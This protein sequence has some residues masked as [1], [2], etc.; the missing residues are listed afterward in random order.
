MYLSRLI[1]MVL[2]L[3]GVTGMLVAQENYW[4]SFTDKKNSTFSINRPE[5]FLS[6]R[7]IQ[8]RIR[9][10]IATDSLDLPVNR[11]YISQVLIPGVTLV[12]SSKWLNGIT[13]KSEIDTFTRYARSLPFVREVIR[14]KR[15]IA[16]K[17]GI[18]KFYVPTVPD[19][20]LPVD[21]SFYGESVFQVTQLNGHYL[22]QRGFL[23]QGIHIAVLDGGF[24]HADTLSA[25]DSLW[26]NGQILG[27]KDF[28]DPGEP[29]FETNYHGMSVLSC[30]GGNLP[31]KLMGTAPKASYWLIRSEDTG[32]EFII[33]ED[34][35]VAAA[36]FAD[37]AGVDIINSSLGYSLFDDPLTQ[38]T[39]ADMDG[40]TTRVT[41]GA[42][43]AASRGILV[44]S[45][46]GNEGNKSWKYIIAP[47]DGDLVIGV[48]AVSRDG[49]PAFFT[50]Y[51]P[52]SDGDIKP[53]VS[54]MG[55]NTFL[56]RNTGVT[57]PGSG[58]SFSSPVVTGV[59]ACLWQACPE[60]TAAE[61]KNAIEKSAHLYESPD[62][63]LGYG[64][65]DMIRAARF[66][67]FTNIPLQDD[68]NPWH[69]YPNPVIDR[70]VL[71]RMGANMQMPVIITLT[72]ADGRIWYNKRID[73]T[74]SPVTIATGELPSGLFLLSVVTGSSVKTF[75]IIKNR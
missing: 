3:T 36:E 11:E 43:I 60:A 47:S 23:G 64:I 25:F 56:V 31:G 44:F 16:G 6:P 71:Q 33:E 18:S 42:N 1:Y 19:D 22:H 39:Y 62:S 75:K 53:N 34:N 41:R 38:H 37:S 32:S 26:I 48:G 8:R 74:D 72:S 45:S 20:H 29:F 51:G 27:I 10:N 55:Y 28:V 5:E 35:W 49:E 67:G 63:L 7:A 54:G 2:I 61:V 59:A 15:N 40:K 21:S 13:V 57:G 14:T 24:F 58:T 50:S 70:L 4:V 52:A 65:P 73:M 9:Q 12:H 17:S 68:P 30:M 66:L 46:A 69:V